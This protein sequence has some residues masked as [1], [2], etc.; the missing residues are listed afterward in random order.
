MANL[1]CLRPSSINASHFFGSMR[2]LCNPWSAL[3]AVHMGEYQVHWL[4]KKV[5]SVSGHPTIDT[6][7]YAKKIISY[8]EP[9]IIFDK[10]Y[11][12]LFK[13]KLFLNIKVWSIRERDVFLNI[14]HSWLIVVAANEYNFREDS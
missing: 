6:V 12:S 8:L 9:I 7:G 13:F 11:L 3:K 14:I 4:S 10:G 2:H 5:F 1:I